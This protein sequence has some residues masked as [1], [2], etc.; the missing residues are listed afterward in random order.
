MPE[1][2]LKRVKEKIR[3]QDWRA[4]PN[5]ENRCWDDFGWGREDMGRCILKLND[6]HHLADQRRNHFYKSEPF[7][8]EPHLLLDFYKAHNIMDGESVYIHL[9]IREEDDK[10]IINSFHQL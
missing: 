8:R 5:A 1:Y 4:T 9:Y 3:A 7:E 2:S 10:L 6:K